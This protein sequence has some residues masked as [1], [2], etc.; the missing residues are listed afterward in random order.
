MED[1]PQGMSR[2]VAG[3]AGIVAAVAGAG[4]EAEGAVAGIAAG[5][6]PSIAAVAAEGWPEWRH[7]AAADVQAEEWMLW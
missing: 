2:P 5:V 7:L 6:A 4:T 3:A 1:K